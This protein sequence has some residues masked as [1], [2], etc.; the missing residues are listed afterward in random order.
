MIIHKISGSPI[1]CS[2]C[3]TRFLPTV[4]SNELAFHEKGEC[5]KN[6][7]KNSPMVQEAIKIGGFLTSM[8]KKVK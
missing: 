4:D 8:K 5:V 2:L 3:G 6:I 1:K 7:V